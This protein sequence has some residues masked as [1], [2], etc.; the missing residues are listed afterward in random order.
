L[1]CEVILPVITSRK[2]ALPNNFRFIKVTSDVLNRVQ[3]LLRSNNLPF[4]DCGDH[5]SNF[6]GIVQEKQIIA[7]GGFEHVGRFALLRSVAVDAQYRGLGLGSSLIQKILGKLTLL[8]IEAI[9][10]LTETG[11]QYFS[12]FGFK[13][14]E[15]DKLPVEIQTT[16]QCQALCPA[17][18]IAI[19]LAL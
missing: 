4:E 3:A 11:D 18:A 6:I 16:Q 10:I 17:F 9:Y 15:R 1:G 2:I 19:R 5:L 13:V 12:Q 14:V 7:I 8:K